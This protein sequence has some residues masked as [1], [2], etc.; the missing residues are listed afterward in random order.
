MNT[1]DPQRWLC[2]TC[3]LP[4]LNL[5]PGDAYLREFLTSFELPHCLAT[6]SLQSNR[7]RAKASVWVKIP[8]LVEFLLF[9]NKSGSYCLCIWAE[10]GRSEYIN[11]K[12]K[13]EKKVVFK[14]QEVHIP[15]VKLGPFNNDYDNNNNNKKRKKETED[16]FT[17]QYCIE[18]QLMKLKPKLH[19]WFC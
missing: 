3:C 6:G 8:K 12:K 18:S 19:F 4:R 2:I 13:K 16:I 1:F 5:W 15:A 11:R 14:N 17:T 9:C 7:K 10:V